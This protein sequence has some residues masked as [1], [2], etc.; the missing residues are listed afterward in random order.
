M[1]PKIREV[2][3]QPTVTG[4]QQGILLSDPLGI[5]TRTLFVSRH[6]MPVL[7]LLDGTRD[8]ETIRAGFELRSGTRLST[9][10]LE[11]LIRELDDALF[12]DNE[13]FL[14]AYAL[15]TEGFRSAPSRPPVLAGN[16]YP[17]DAEQ[18][19]A[20]LQRYFDQAEDVDTESLSEVKGL[21]SPHIDFLRGGP[22]YARVWAKAK[23]AVNE[24]ELVVILGTDHNGGEGTV[25]LTRQNYETP[26]GVLPTAQDVVN[27]IAEQAGDD[28]FR[29]E[30]HHRVEHSVEAAIVWLQHLLG[31]K[32]CH[33]LPVLCGSFRQF[34]DRGESPSQSAHISATIKT[35]RGVGARWRTLI[36]AA[37]DL[38]HV[39]PAFG[40]QY[41]MDFVG[42]ATLASQDQKLI[43]IMSR[44]QAEDFFEEIRREG[45]QR[46]VCGMPPIYVAESL[47]S[48][49]KGSSVG[50]A[51]CPASADGSS[52]VSICGMIYHA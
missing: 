2:R 52:L 25:T 38:A 40:D 26:L 17:A 14:Q 5:S 42:R 23:A 16:C 6:L 34:I 37:G 49:V 12:L 4:G 50:Y 18:L 20:F 21:V 36:V 30:L 29:H 43:D 31:G 46:R 35:L 48:G 10:I 47:L 22:I 27:E 32:R 19:A 11:R 13:R 15:A 45:D 9:P 39:G 28:A 7:A 41:P 8:I 33:I 24:A 1:N 51:Q 44:V 3:P